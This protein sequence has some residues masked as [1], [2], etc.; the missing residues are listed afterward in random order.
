MSWQPVARCSKPRAIMSRI[1]SGEVTSAGTNSCLLTQLVIEACVYETRV[2]H[3]S[4]SIWSV[5]QRIALGMSGR[6][7]AA[8]SMLECIYFS[9]AHNMIALQSWL[10]SCHMQA[11]RRKG[12]R[13]GMCPPTWA[14]SGTLNPAPEVALTSSTSFL[15]PSDSRSHTCREKFFSQTLCSIPLA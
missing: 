2:V 6:T 4:G 1:C 14:R 7:P 13:E 15:P 8:F 3:D 11:F 9:I 5:R 10:Q 12:N